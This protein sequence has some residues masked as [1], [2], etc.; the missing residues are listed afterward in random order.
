[1]RAYINRVMLTLYILYMN[2][3]SIVQFNVYMEL[4]FP[5]LPVMQCYARQ[6]G[7]YAVNGGSPRRYHRVAGVAALIK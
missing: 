5:P 6:V 4:S 7:K 1:M 2:Y 3:T